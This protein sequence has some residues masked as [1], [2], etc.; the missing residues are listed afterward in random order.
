MRIGASERGRRTIFKAGTPQLAVCF[1]W[2]PVFLND[3]QRR[4]IDRN[5][6]AQL[7]TDFEGTREDDSRE[8]R[9]SSRQ[10]IEVLRRQHD[11]TWKLIMR[12][13]NGRECNSRTDPTHA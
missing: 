8:R 6:I 3:I 13:P 11:G 10:A 2:V 12:D 5:A 4:N 9:L 7:Y 1:S